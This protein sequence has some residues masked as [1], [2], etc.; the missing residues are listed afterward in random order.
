MGY[1]AES[2]YWGGNLG[3]G[4]LF[5]NDSIK[6]DLYSRFYWTEVDGDSF[7]LD[8]DSSEFRDISRRRVRIG[9]R[10]ESFDWGVY[11]RTAYEHEFDGDASMTAAGIRAPI[12]ALKGNSFMGELG[13]KYQMTKLPFLL[14]LK[15]AGWSGE[16]ARISGQTRLAYEF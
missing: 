12:E 14:D 5:E 13:G 7:S 8:G 4:H 2:F 6:L 3:F 9:S 16:Q 10:I 15:A 1:D 11:F